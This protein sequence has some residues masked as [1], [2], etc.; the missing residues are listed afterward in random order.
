MYEKLNITENHLQ[1]LSLFTQGFKREYYIREVQRLLKMSPRTAQLILND[2][3]K[4]AV[5][6]SKR[7]GKIRTYALKSST[8]ARDCIIFVEEYKKILFVQK[9]PMIQEI[10][11]KIIPCIAGIGVIF[12]SYARGTEKKDSD[13][14]IFIAGT[15]NKNEIKKIS[16]RYGIE[17]S[18]KSYPI[19]I[20]EETIN[21]DILLKEVIANHI[22]FCNIDGFVRAALKNG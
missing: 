20:F 6:E 7:R 14:D 13:L 22:V 1:V 9:H 16:E 12:G 8:I 18:I 15:Y 19:K 4:K 2:W 21:E 17:V 10:I 5:L 3:E 11:T